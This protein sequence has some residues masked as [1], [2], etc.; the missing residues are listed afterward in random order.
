MLLGRGCLRRVR[1]F[2][3]TGIPALACG[4]VPVP[5]S[6]ENGSSHARREGLAALGRAEGRP[7]P[8]LESCDPLLSSLWCV[9]I[10]LRTRH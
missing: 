2:C 10:F 9:S 8:R 3:E 4:L 7:L 5:G 1:R 6:A